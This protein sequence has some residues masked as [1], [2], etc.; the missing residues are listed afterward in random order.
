M[1]NPAGGGGHKQWSGDAMKQA[2]YL[3]CRNGNLSS[4]SR[5]HEKAVGEEHACNSNQIGEIG[6]KSFL[7]AGQ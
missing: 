3:S 2:K 1:Q 6:L 7:E 5:R 4:L